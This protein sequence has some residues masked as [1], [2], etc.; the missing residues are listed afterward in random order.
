MESIMIKA[1]GY[2]EEFADTSGMKKRLTAEEEESAFIKTLA[3]Y[4]LL[5]EVPFPYLLPAEA[6]LEP[7]SLRFFTLD[8]GWIFSLLDGVCSIGRNTKYDYSHDNALILEAMQY[9]YQK[10]A[11]VRPELAGKTRRTEEKITIDGSRIGGFLLRSRLVSDYNGIEMKGFD[12]D[13][14]ELPILRLEQVA[15]DILLGLYGGLVNRLRLIQPK[16]SL[17]LGCRLSRLRDL[18]TGAGN[19]ALKLKRETEWKGRTLQVDALVENMKESLGTEG[20]PIA[21]EEFTSAELALELIQNALTI[22]FVLE[23]K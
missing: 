4:S 7:E 13:K 5:Y 8:A 3:E 11:Q 17:H 14:K 9:A 22:D 1:A 2:T 20:H 16:E 19:S 23:N 18:K 15:P 6:Y 21:D 10:A 12:A